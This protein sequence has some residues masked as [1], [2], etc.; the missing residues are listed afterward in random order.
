M[1]LVTMIK[2]LINIW[3]KLHSNLMIMLFSSF[4]EKEE[5]QKL[6]NEWINTNSEI[7]SFLQTI[8]KILIYFIKSSVNFMKLWIQEI[9][10]DIQKN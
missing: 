10:K 8:Y 9:R 6:K 2:I 4:L 5:I 3:K 1:N 7:N